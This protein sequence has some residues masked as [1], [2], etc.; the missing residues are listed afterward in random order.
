MKTAQTRPSASKRVWLRL[1]GPWLRFF[2][3]WSGL[4]ALIS[5][6]SVCPCCG[7]PACPAGA[8]SAWLLGGMLTAGFYLPRRLW[9]LGGSLL[10]CL[11]TEH[12]KTVEGGR[13]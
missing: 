5:G 2:G 1:V 4:F 12:G 7:K 8:F 13:P 11:R 10:A 3:M 6:S 9:R